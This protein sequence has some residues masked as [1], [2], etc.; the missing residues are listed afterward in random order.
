MYNYTSKSYMKTGYYT[1]S[2]IGIWKEDN[3]FIQV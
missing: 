3:L 1:I 2:I